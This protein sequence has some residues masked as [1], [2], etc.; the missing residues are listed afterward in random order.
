[1]Q[2]SLH[3]AANGHLSLELGDYESKLWKEISRHLEAELGFSRIGD[4]V[5]GCDEGIRQSFE[6]E[7]LLI[8]AGWDN[9]SGDY[10]LSESSLGDELLQSLFARFR[11]NISLGSDTQRQDVASRQLRRA[12]QLFNHGKSIFSTSR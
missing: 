8:S 5:V 2:L 9:W 10:F 12:G 1:M 3:T 4:A 11:P 6:R 7:G